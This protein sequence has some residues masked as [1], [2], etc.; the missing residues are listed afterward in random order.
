[1][2]YTHKHP[3]PHT[4]T[5][6]AVGCKSLFFALLLE[7][8][9]SVPSDS[10]QI[11]KTLTD[12]YWNL[13]DPFSC[14]FSQTKSQPKTQQLSARFGL[15]FN[16]FLLQLLKFSVRIKLSY[17]FFASTTI[18]SIQNTDTPITVFD[19]TLAVQKFV[20]FGSFQ[21]AENDIFT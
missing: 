20:L 2:T 19:T 14:V 9:N 17:F 3:P 10:F 6:T 4:H 11:R 16:I 7:F 18:L 13:V 1:M 5:S 15:Q 8:P 21:R 12:I